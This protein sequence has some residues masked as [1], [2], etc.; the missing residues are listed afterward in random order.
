MT[1][2]E[3]KVWVDYI[4]RKNHTWP[5]ILDDKEHMLHWTG[6]LYI[7]RA[8]FKDYQE[9]DGAY[10][11][12][13]EIYLENEIRYSNDLF[14]SYEEYMEDKVI[15]FRDMAELSYMVTKDPAQSIVLIDAALS[16]LDS[17]ESIGPYID[18]REFEELRLS[19]L[20]KEKQGQVH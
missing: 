9:Y 12:M 11:I 13:N 16:M 14:G 8:L 20:D 2:E 4:K 18:Q 6:R 15:F 1:L 19:Y 3:I 10:L 17:S 7:A 5:S